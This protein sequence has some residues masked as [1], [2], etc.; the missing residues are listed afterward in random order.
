MHDL[1]IM[2]YHAVSPTW[3]AELS[4]RPD[5]FEAQIEL[6]A[7]RGYRGAGFS[8]ALAGGRAGRVVSVTFDDAYRSVLELAKPV[9]DRHSY[10][11]TI[12]VVSNW[13]DA[14][15]PMCWK[16]VDIWLDTQHEQE[17]TPL[18]WPE[19]RT[20]ANEGWEIGSHTCSHPV[21]TSIDDDTL[22]TEL[23]DSK[24]RIEEELGRPCTSLAYPYGVH[25]ARVVEAARAA[26]YDWACT[27][28]RVLP[29]PA[30]LVWPRT[31]IYHDDD[32]RRFAAKVSPAMRRIRTSALGTV[33]DRLR[34]A[35]AARLEPR[36]PSRETPPGP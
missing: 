30:P 10:P 28:P 16:G 11:G 29:T 33:F 6:L 5:A 34:V 31:P 26:G 32:L 35:A 25:D 22:A 12:F 8:A 14:G 21:L 19:L 27:I 9:L 4:V 7:G 1:L 3:P 17:L 36:V 15:R 20:L 13:P 23:R 18:T 24:A 2:C